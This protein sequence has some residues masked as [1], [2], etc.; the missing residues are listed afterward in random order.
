MKD[1][2]LP[3]FCIDWRRRPTL[4]SVFEIRSDLALALRE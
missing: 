2:N 1:Q 3:L 4:I